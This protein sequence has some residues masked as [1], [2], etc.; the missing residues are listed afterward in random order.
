MGVHSNSNK[1]QDFKIN[2]LTLSII[3]KSIFYLRKINASEVSNIISKIKGKL[4]PGKDEI[5]TNV[6][7]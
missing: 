3:F 4:A 2:L 5:S 6:I 7:E 1:T